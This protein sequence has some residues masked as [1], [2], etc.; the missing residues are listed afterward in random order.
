MR[1]LDPKDRDLHRHKALLPKE[2]HRH[3]QL[4]PVKLKDEEP[5]WEPIQGPKT[6]REQRAYATEHFPALPEAEQRFLAKQKLP[7]V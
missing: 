3:K 2:A 6:L 5:K 4:A 7:E 1:Y